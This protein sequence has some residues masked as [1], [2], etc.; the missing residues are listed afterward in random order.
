MTVY[1]I[2]AFNV[3]Q[4]YKKKICENNITLFSKILTVYTVI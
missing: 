4:F 1:N 3:A 2:F